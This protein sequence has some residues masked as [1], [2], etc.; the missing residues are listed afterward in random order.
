MEIRLTS[1]DIVRHDLSTRMPFKYGIA[2]MTHLPHVFIRIEA[3]FGGRSVRGV[4]AD[5][6]PPKWFTKDAEKDPLDEIEDMLR[7]IRSA[8]DHAGTITATSVFDFWFQLYQLQDAWRREQSIPP[9]LAHFGTSLIERAM[10][11]ALC[12]FTGET[13]KSLLQRD[14]FEL[15]WGSVRPELE[16]HRPSDLLGEH[17]LSRVTVRHTVGLADYIREDEIPDDERLDDGLPQSLE[18][19]MAFYGVTHFKI[20]IGGELDA[21]VKRLAQI[22]ALL[23]SIGDSDYAFSLDGN[24]QFRS[25]ADLQQFWHRLENDDTLVPFFRHLLFVEQPFHRDIAL[26][27]DAIGPDLRSWEEA[28]PIIIDESDATLDSLPQAL[29]LGYRGTSH[30]NCK[31]VFKGIINRATLALKNRQRGEERYLM[32]GE[33]LANIGPIA[34]H[35]DLVVQAALGIESVERNGHHYFNGLSQFDPEL[36]NATKAVFP[37]LYT[38]DGNGFVRLNVSKGEL[39]LSSLNAAGF[40]V[41]TIQFQ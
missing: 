30:K 9:L 5:H 11:D 8:G 26:S 3:S 35:Q 28:P 18:S 17:S 34:N 12:Q 7:V 29:A 4:S 25:V 14:A 21:D 31:G 10:I 20:K 19:V 22:A 16:G 41:D 1:F 24:E 40:G 6:L 23:E 39:D 2:T 32:S 33:D 27:E 38:T 37:S 36:Q 13:F 15:A